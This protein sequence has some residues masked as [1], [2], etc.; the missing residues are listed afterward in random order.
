MPVTTFRPHSR[1]RGMTRQQANGMP[2]CRPLDRRA[3]GR[4]AP[5]AR[6]PRAWPWPWA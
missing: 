5:A 2:R 4:N 3:F 6:R 1:R